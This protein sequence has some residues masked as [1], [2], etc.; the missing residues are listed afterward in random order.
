MRTISDLNAARIVDEATDRILELE[1]ALRQ[2]A[3]QPK[4]DA[5]AASSMHAIARGALI[6]KSSGRHDPVTATTTGSV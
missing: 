1:A 4:L 2:I 5:A 3:N 6:K